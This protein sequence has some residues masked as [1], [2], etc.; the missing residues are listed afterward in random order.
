MKLAAVDL[1]SNSLRLVVARYNRGEMKVV[2][3]EL[4]ET[5]LGQCLQPGGKLLPHV[6]ERN[7]KA[8]K[9]LYDFLMQLNVSLYCAFGTSAIREAEDGQLFLD[10][11]EQ[12]VGFPTL[13]LSSKEEAFLG[14][15]STNLVFPG[16]GREVVVLDAGGRSTEISWQ[17]GK[18]FC[19]RSLPVGA[20][21]LQEV[22]IKN[23]PPAKEDLTRLD[24]YLKL[25]LQPLPRFFCSPH[26]RFLVGIGGTI[27]TLAAIHLQLAEYIP[28]RVHGRTL[29]TEDLEKIIHFLHDKPLK[30]R[31][32]IPGLPPKR[33]DVIIPGAIAFLRCME[34][35]G[36]TR[37]VV[38]QGG[39]LP[40]A[41]HL[42]AGPF[43][44][45]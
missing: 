12:E 8:L 18:N 2:H 11:I 22:I 20:V 24:K 43:P 19:F 31:E 25:N 17:Q 15:L 30:E 33:A 45:A 16:E 38:N 34:H 3:R 36:F 39:F 44:R 13:L 5:R 26:E 23:D 21:R 40:A 7:L 14:L 27:T 32:K 10:R 35:M 41:L 42:L 4:K 9:E 6:V 1:G 37:L 28:S 29:T